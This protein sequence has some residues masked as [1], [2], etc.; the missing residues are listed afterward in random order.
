PQATWAYKIMKRINGRLLTLARL[1]RAAG[2]YGRNNVGLHRYSRA[3]GLGIKGNLPGLLKGL[4][5]WL[6]VELECFAHQLRH[7]RVDTSG[8][9]A[10]R[11][12]AGKMPKMEAQPG[13][14]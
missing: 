14:A 7:G 1:R 6:K 8:P 3:F 2:T 12:M 5:I 11:P 9:V 4:R 13:P 10:G